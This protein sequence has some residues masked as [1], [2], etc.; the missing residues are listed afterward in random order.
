MLSICRKLL[1]NRFG[2]GILG[3]PGAISLRIFAKLRNL[4]QKEV[5]PI[6][7]GLLKWTGEGIFFLETIM[8]RLRVQME[9]VMMFINRKNHNLRLLLSQANFLITQN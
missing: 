7:I 5:K 1:Q 8:C 3:E 2:S 4:Q 9:H 6:W